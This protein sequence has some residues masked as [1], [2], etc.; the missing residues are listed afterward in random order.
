MESI[1]VF[2]PASVANVSCGYDIF[3]FALN[4][5]G[6]EITLTKRDDS[7]LVIKEIEGAEVPTEPKKNVATV[8]IA[9]LLNHLNSKQGFDISIKKKIPPCSGLGSS[10]C[11]ASGAVFAAS[12]LLHTGMSKHALIPFAMD[13]EFIASKTYH[14]DNIASALL[15]GFTVAR[16]VEPEVD[17]FNIP[18]PEDLKVLIVFPQV[19]VKTSEAKQLLGDTVDLKK[20]RVQWGN[21]AGLATGLISKDWNLIERS[22]IDVIAE[23]LRKKFIPNYD[24]VKK[25]AKE[26]GAMGFNISGSGPSMF[27]FYRDAEKAKQVIPEIKYLFEQQS[28]ACLFF[29][30]EINGNG[31]QV[32]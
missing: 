27:G 21:V 19:K 9:S 10:A 5:I 28:I 25:L 4:E 22:M 29:T 16:S 24:Q 14:A 12:E 26:S 18:Y 7:Q 32:M 3:G 2:A 6:D 1:K 11:S 13:G 8:A 15:G 31:A 17:V 23:P 30:S 20:A